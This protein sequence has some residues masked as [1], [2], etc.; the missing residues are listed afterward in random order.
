MP[1]VRTR[2]FTSWGP[3]GSTSAS[4]ILR[5]RGEWMM[6]AFI[7]V[8]PTSILW[9]A[10]CGSAGRKHFQVAVEQRRVDPP[11]Q[12]IEHAVAEGDQLVGGGGCF[13][14]PVCCDRLE[15]GQVAIQR[16]AQAFVW[17]HPTVVD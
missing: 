17:A 8:L 14:D 9:L 4:S 13:L 3:T 1:P 11:S 15:D 16:P 6:A 2:T 12:H 10:A 5:S 7:G